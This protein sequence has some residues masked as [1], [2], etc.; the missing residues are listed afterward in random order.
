MSLLRAGIP[1]TLPAIFAYGSVCVLALSPLLA[2]EG[3]ARDA[4]DLKTRDPLLVGAAGGSHSCHGAACF[5]LASTN[6]HIR[7]QEG[8][9]G[10]R[11][12]M[13]RQRTTDTRLP[14]SGR[15]C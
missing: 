10:S 3:P 12:Y 11:G 2:P 13:M 6:A 9:E 8:L 15:S 1:L 5:C 14:S 7:E 4:A